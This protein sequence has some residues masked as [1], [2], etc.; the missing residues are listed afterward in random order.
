MYNVL[1]ETR[2]FPSEIQSVTWIMPC[3]PRYS[4]LSLPSLPWWIGFKFL[5]L[6]FQ[7]SLCFCQF[8]VLLNTIKA[9]IKLSSCSEGLR[10]TAWHPAGSGSNRNNSKTCGFLWN[11]NAVLNFFSPTFNSA[12]CTLLLFLTQKPM[13]HGRKEL[14]N[15]LWYD[16][17]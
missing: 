11:Q 4:S 5:Q 10:D 13:P 6:L 16:L 8:I 12:Y 3:F 17:T 9:H 7:L 14:L 15:A 1:R 2:T